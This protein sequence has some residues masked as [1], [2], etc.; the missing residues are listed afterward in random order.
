[1]KSAKKSKKA[2][3]RKYDKTKVQKSLIKV[4]FPTNPKEILSTF[5]RTDLPLPVPT[6]YEIF[7]ITI[8]TIAQFIDWRVQDMQ[9]T[10]NL[11]KT[12]HLI[13]PQDFYNLATKLTDAF[14]ATKFG[15]PKLFD[16]NIVAA[17]KTQTVDDVVKIA[18]AIFGR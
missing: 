8:A 2:S 17:T 13:R 14:Q 10:D 4:H 15:C 16:P 5:S 6:S 7:Q 12:Y 3:S 1:M 18:Y 9:I 11:E